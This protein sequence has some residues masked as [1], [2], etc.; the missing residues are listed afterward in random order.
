MADDLLA[1]VDGLA[2]WA[3]QPLMHAVRVHPDDRSRLQFQKITGAAPWPVVDISSE[4]TPR[5]DTD[6]RRSIQVLHRV[7]D[8][9]R[10]IDLFPFASMVEQP[11]KTPVPALLVP[12]A[13]GRVIRRSLVTGEEIPD[14]PLRSEEWDGLRSVFR[15]ELGA[16]R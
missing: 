3:D 10:L 8:R 9:E 11:G 5:R 12:G 6:R 1:L 7:G 16:V 13:N 4:A 14:I 15:G 2:F